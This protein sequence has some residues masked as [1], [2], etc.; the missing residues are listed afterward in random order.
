M[1]RHIDAVTQLSQF[2]SQSFPSIYNPSIYNMKNHKQVKRHYPQHYLRWLWAVAGLGLLGVL[3]GCNN[4]PAALD[5][6]GPAAADINTLTWFLIILGTLVYIGV[7]VFLIMGLI[8]RRQSTTGQPS[9]ATDDDEHFALGNIPDEADPPTG[10]RI[11]VWG[12]IVMPAIVLLVVG[13][14]GLNTLMAIATDPNDEEITIDVI[15]HQWW[16]EVVYPEQEIVTANE[17]Y[18][19][20]GQPVRINLTAAGV[21]HS[22]W[23]PQLHGKLDMIPGRTN[24]FRIQADAVGEYRGICAEFC[25]I[26]HARM[27]FLVIAVEPA[28]FEQWLAQQAAPA[29]VPETV[30]AQQGE[31]YFMETPC[32]SCHAIAGTPAEGRLGP[33]LTHFASRREIGAGTMD[34]TRANLAGW[35]VNSYETKPGNLMPPTTLTEDELNALLDY[36][37]MLE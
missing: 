18:V 9:V 27:L 11:V 24:S 20:V 14:M 26:Q 6:Q 17:I 37:L 13:G 16:W 1:S 35:I 5:P 10:R 34:N 7:S 12:G 19:P 30:S 31:T 2:D 28:E 4:A 8:R 29:P 25:G 23:V 21:V 15:G 3:S 36:L 33:D 32:A 22:F